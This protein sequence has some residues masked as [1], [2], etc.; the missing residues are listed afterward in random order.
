[1]QGNLRYIGFLHP[2]RP[3]PGTVGDEQQDGGTG[4]VLNQRHQEC[5]RSLVAPVQILDGDDEGV[6][7]TGTQEEPA[8]H[9]EGVS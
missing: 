3:I 9:V 1:M 2:R 5:L 8:K 4:Q 7:S 6:L